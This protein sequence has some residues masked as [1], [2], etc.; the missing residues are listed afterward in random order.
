MPLNLSRPRAAPTLGKPRRGTELRVEA[1]ERFPRTNIVI[2]LR[3]QGGPWSQRDPEDQRRIDRYKA[4]V[5]RGEFGQLT[6]TLDGSPLGWAFPTREELVNITDA[7]LRGEDLR[8]TRPEQPSLVEVRHHHTTVVTEIGMTVDE[9]SPTMLTV[10]N[11]ITKEELQRYNA[12][13]I[14][15]VRVCVE[16]IYRQLVEEAE[17]QRTK[18][19]LSNTTI[20]PVSH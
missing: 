8:Y 14:E 18:Q 2:G 11:R 3:S 15:V 6:T 19:V 4:A 1:R 10:G 5:D 17:K 7:A 13:A 16:S 12:D 9:F 20:S